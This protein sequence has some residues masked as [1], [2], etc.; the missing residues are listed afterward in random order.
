LVSQQVHVCFVLSAE[1][2]Q[3][4]TQA[5]IEHLNSF[6]GHDLKIETET[7]TNWDEFEKWK[8]TEEEMSKSWFVKKRGDRMTK[9]YKTSWF[10]CNMIGEYESKGKGK[11]S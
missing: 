11:R 4:T 5:L 1:N 9:Q 10:R 7:F 2:C 6:H 8:E 3:E